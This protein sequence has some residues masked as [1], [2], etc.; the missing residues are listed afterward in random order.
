MDLT[1]RPLHVS[2]AGASLELG[3][4][5]LFAYGRRA[6]A[7][8]PRWLDIPGAPVSSPSSARELHTAVGETLRAWWGE[9]A[10]PTHAFPVQ[11]AA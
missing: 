10:P 7:T 3:R 1:R 9:T 4:V 8:P 5:P 11:H 2:N 6:A